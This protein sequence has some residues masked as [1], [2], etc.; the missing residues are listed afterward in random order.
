MSEAGDNMSATP[1]GDFLNELCIARYGVD[2]DEC[3][4]RG[5]DTR[6][7]TQQVLEHRWPHLR[8]NRR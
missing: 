1:Y 4:A 2:F 8:K 3:Q 7:L 6:D 5:Y